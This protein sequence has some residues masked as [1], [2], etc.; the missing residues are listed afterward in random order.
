MRDNVTEALEP[1]ASV[2]DHQTTIGDQQRDLM[3]IRAH[4]RGA[5]RELDAFLQKATTALCRIYGSDG[6]GET[7]TLQDVLG[8][9]EEAAD[10]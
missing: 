10:G 4:L 5:Q 8:Y 1:S 2:V 6:D 3:P 7:V 9:L